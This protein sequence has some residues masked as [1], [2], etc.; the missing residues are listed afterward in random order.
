M[1]SEPRE[2]W[3]YDDAYELTKKEQEIRDYYMATYHHEAISTALSNAFRGKSG[4]YHEW[5]TK[6]IQEEIRE[7]TGRYT[8]KEK[9]AKLNALFGGLETMQANFNM[10]KEKE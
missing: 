8:E 7:H 6:T 2:L 10:S 1:D 4:K 9:Q 3:C 5:R